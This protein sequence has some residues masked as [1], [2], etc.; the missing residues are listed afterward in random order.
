MIMMYLSKSWQA[1][2]LIPWGIFK[3][4]GNFTCKTLPRLKYFSDLFLKEASKDDILFEH[5]LILHDS[6]SN[7]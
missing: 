1:D 5:G 3:E 7:S 6:N 2:L 4:L